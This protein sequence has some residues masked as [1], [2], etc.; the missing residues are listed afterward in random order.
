MVTLFSEGKA[1]DAA[2]RAAAEAYVAGPHSQQKLDEGM[3]SETL[4]AN[5]A[6]KLPPDLELSADQIAEIG[7][8]ISEAMFSIRPEVEQV[9]ISAL[10]KIHTIEEIQ[11]MDAYFNS[12]AGLSAQSKSQQFEQVFLSAMKSSIA[13]AGEGRRKQIRDVIIAR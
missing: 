13:S 5:F 2:R 8:I 6:A 12:P 7:S 3:S 9:M 10:A 11:A 4:A 1:D